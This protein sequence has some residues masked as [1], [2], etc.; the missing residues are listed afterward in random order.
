MAAKSFNIIENKLWTECQNLAKSL[1]LGPT[2][3]PPGSAHH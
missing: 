1:R 2:V 3:E